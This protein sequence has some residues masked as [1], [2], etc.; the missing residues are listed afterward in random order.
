MEALSFAAQIA[1]LG[2]FVATRQAE[3][4][5]ERKRYERRVEQQ[6]KTKCPS[7]AKTAISPSQQ[8]LAAMEPNKGYR[9]GDL[10]LLTGLSKAEFSPALSQLCKANKVHMDYAMRASL[11]YLN[12]D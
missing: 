4:D 12:R 5:A 8:I 1:D 3:K 6:R 9:W 10:L 7:P 11:Y 2:Q